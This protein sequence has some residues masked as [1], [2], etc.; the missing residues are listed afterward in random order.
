MMPKTE[1]S[2]DDAAEECLTLVNWEDPA[3]KKERRRA[4]HKGLRSQGGGVVQ[5]EHF[6]YKGGGGG[7]FFAILCEH[8]LWM[9]P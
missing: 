3:I 1:T 5:C 8:L 2:G 4:V 9:A 7:Q 6:A